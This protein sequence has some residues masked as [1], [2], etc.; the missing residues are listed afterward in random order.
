[1]KF[2]RSI[3]ENLKDPKKRSITLLVIYAVFF[4]FVI[5]LIRTGDKA[6]YNPVNNE[7][8]DIIESYEFR[9]IINDNINKEEISGIW[10]GSTYSLTNGEEINFEIEMFSYWNIE[11]LIDN[12]EFVKKT[13]YKD[14][15]EETIYN[16]QVKEY[17]ELLNI[18]NEC[19]EN[20]CNDIT[21]DI[22]VQSLDYIESVTIDL[23]NYYSYDY[24]INI[25]YSNINNI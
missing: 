24:N 8:D 1:M 17:F 19:L 11:K 3:K 6:V 9:Y 13:T 5:L 14:G 23:K 10:D 16:I 18:D 12:S 25:T 15:K 4:A 7:S 21:V 2:F 22:S 20:S